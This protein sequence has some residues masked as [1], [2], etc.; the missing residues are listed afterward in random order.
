MHEQRSGRHPGGVLGLVPWVVGASL[1]ATWPLGTHGG[2]AAGVHAGHG[3]WWRRLLGLLA[4]ALVG[5]SV[6]LLADRGLAGAV[7]GMALAGLGRSIAGRLTDWQSQPA[8]E[9]VDDAGR[10]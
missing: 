8:F 10:R 1:S 2:T 9:D 6:A 5:A 3:A 7:T 4:V